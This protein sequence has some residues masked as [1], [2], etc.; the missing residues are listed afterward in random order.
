ME[1]GRI[2][3]THYTEHLNKIAQFLWGKKLDAD[4]LATI[5]SYTENHPYYLN[6]LCDRIVTLHEKKPPSSH[7]IDMIWMDILQEE[8]SDAIKE[9]LALPAGQK[10]ALLYI[11]QGQTSKISSKESMLALNMTT[12]S[13]YTAL[14]G[15]EEKDIIEKIDKQYRIINPVIKYYV[16]K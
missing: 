9:I 4:V 13:I 11:A 15:L 16:L 14:T 3:E 7:D 12:S 2:A 5:F 8:K 6:K 1:L 10:K